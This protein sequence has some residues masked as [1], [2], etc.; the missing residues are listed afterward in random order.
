MDI[1]PVTPVPQDRRA[2]RIAT[3]MAEPAATTAYVEDFLVALASYTEGHI[4]LAAFLTLTDP[5]AR[6]APPGVG[7]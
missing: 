6:T 5:E 3:V 4:D 7:R 2:N 1:N